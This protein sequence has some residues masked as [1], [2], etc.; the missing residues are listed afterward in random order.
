M[1][2]LRSLMPDITP[3]VTYYHVVNMND[4][5]GT[6]LALLISKKEQGGINLG[7]REPQ[8]GLQDP[9]QL[10]HCTMHVGRLAAHTPA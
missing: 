3:I 5:Q 1:Q 4:H 9:G 7:F 6:E 8:L 2:L 10:V